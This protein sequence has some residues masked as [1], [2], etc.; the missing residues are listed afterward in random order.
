MTKKK[1]KADDA[2]NGLAAVAAAVDDPMPAAEGELLDPVSPA[3][4]IAEY[5]PTEA[6]LAELRKQYATVPDVTTKDGMV[7]A[8]EARRNM[9][10]LRTQ[11][12]SVRKQIKAPILERG[13][14]IDAE[15]KRITGEIQ[16]VEQPFDDAIKA[17]EDRIEAAREAN[18]KRAAERQAKVDAWMA[19]IRDLPLKYL[20]ADAET[21][22]RVVHQSKEQAFPP[23]GL[24]GLTEEEIIAAARLNE[25]THERLTVMLEARQ[26]AD[27]VRAEQEAERQRLADERAAHDVEVAAQR[28]RDEADAA[29]RRE[30]DRRLLQMSTHGSSRAKVDAIQTAI[31]EVQAMDTS[32]EVFGA[33]VD[34]AKRAQ[35]SAMER[36]QQQLTIA[37]E[38]ARVAEEQDAE[39]TRL[40]EVAYKPTRARAQSVHQ[41]LKHKCP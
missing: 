5:Q 8:R 15:A 6:G 3:S 28:Q 10:A 36:L 11:V 19:A 34:D 26:E 30:V 17:E 31:A 35:A 29:T 24:E 22:E 23:D 7:L 33:R 1:P 9:V 12:E 37:Q 25:T 38:A 40:A 20:T 32:E 27:K 21:L 4:A 16:K 13:A 39:R 14:L 18:R 2:L 41:S